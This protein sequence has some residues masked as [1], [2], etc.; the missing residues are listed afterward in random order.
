MKVYNLTIGII[1]GLMGMLGYGV[2][3]FFAKKTT[4][5]I[6]Y[7]KTAFWSQLIG[8]VLLLFYLLFDP[9]L[10]QI[11]LRLLVAIFLFGF[12]DAAGLSLF[13]RGMQKGQISIIS[14]FFSSFAVLNVLIAV[15]IF[16]EILSVTKMFGVAML[17]LGTILISVDINQV[18]KTKFLSLKKG[19]PETTLA[20]LIYGIY[21]PFWAVLVSNQG[22]LVIIVLARMFLALTLF[23]FMKFQ[24]ANIRISSREFFRGVGPIGLFGA[25]AALTVSLGLRSSYTSIVAPIS[26]AFSLPTIILA[27][28]FLN[29]CLNLTQALGAIGIISGLVLISL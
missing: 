21:F 11:T 10:P 3:D 17:I 23:A 18:K 1:A 24:P 8:A 2:A 19:I 13:Y 25:V 7:L 26:A 29:E 15:L 6:G 9:T 16:K 22:W 12:L 5:K 27:R 20:V 28:V 14:P 4:D